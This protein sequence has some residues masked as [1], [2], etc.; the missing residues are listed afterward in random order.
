MFANKR[1]NV[2][3]WF[4]IITVLFLM[5]LVLICVKIVADKV[6]ES[7]VFADDTNAQSAIDNTQDTLL[8]FDNLM[9]FV[10]VGLSIFVLVS[11]AMVFNHPAMFFVS[12]ILL[13][14]A[15]VIAASISNAFWV[16]TDSSSIASTAAMFPKVTFIMNKLPFYILFM[17]VA[18]L[19]VSF[20]N[21]R[22][23]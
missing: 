22:R 9:L 23:E 7:G 19:V 14:I 10:I 8:S 6:D 4:Y 1:G 11:S 2:L 3:D 17:G 5:A 18:S 15:I 12:V 21:Y 20:I 16:F 13:F